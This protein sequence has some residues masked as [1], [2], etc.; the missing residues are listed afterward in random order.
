MHDRELTLQSTG[1]QGRYGHE[2]LGIQFTF[3]PPQKFA[4][5]RLS[6]E[7]DF[8]ANGVARYANN[9][10]Y[11]NDSLIRKESM[12]PPHLFWGWGLIVCLVCV[13]PAIIAELKRIVVDSEILK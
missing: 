10:N 1:H 7:F 2:F 8:R 3:P 13:S 9:S 6:V 11:R 12:S 4:A 5:K